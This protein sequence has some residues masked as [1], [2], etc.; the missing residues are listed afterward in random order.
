[1]AGTP[2]QRKEQRRRYRKKYKVRLAKYRTEKA[3]RNRSDWISKNGPCKHCGS[4]DNLQVDHIDPKTKDVNLS[5]KLF[6]VS[7]QR[8][9]SELLK[10]QVLCKPCH[11]KKSCFEL[12]NNGQWIH[13]PNCYK[14]HKCKC[15]ICKDGHAKQV[16]EKRARIKA[17]KLALIETG[18]LVA[19]GAAN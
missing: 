19:S 13:G 18:S 4:T 2:E 1:M 17:K 7:K 5:R 6:F 14:R 16:R 12:P 15:R 8:M 10:C 9:E 3:A 11:H